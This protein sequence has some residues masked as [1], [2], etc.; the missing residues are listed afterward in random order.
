[1]RK[2]LRRIKRLAILG[3]IVGLVFAL[4]K[5]KSA[6]DA[7]QVLGPPASWPPLRAGE[8]PIA[9][10]GDL[11]ADPAAHDVTS[12]PPDVPVVA[13]VPVAAVGLI[14]TDEPA[15]GWVEP[16]DGACPLSHPVKANANSGIYHMPGSQFYERTK[17]ERCYVDAAAAEADGYRA[18]RRTSGSESDRSAQ[19]P[20]PG[21]PAS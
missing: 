9:A 15:P 5:A 11:V 7:R 17:P 3:G 21:G 6:R 10:V 14:D 13:D 2:R 18:A 12:R 16:V 20:H 8:P 1:V 19:S 4:R